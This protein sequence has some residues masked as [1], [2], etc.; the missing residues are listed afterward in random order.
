MKTFVDKRRGTADETR[1]VRQ[2]I[3]HYLPDFLDNYQYQPAKGI[4]RCDKYGEHS[5]Y[6]LPVIQSPGSP[7]IHSYIPNYHVLPALY[8]TQQVMSPNSCTVP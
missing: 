5:F 7:N 3:E 4:F 2:T 6:C 1:T 8:I